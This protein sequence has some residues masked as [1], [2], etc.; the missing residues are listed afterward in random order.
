M[1]KTGI[2]KGIIMLRVKFANFFKNKLLKEFE[3]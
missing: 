3:N 1:F 2:I